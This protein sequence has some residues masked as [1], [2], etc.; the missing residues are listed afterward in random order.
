MEQGVSR[1]IW[2]KYGWIVSQRRI[3]RIMKSL[4]FKAKTK[5]R[6]KIKTTHSNHN[7]PIGSNLINQNLYANTPHKVYVGD[8]TSIKTQEGWLYLTVVIDLY[9]KM[10]VGDAIANPMHT[11]LINHSGS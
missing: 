10:I 9:T 7:L 6:F 5:R 11:T 1:Q 4:G 2:K 8:I 3:G